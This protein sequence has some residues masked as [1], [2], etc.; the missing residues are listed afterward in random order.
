[1]RILILGNNYASEE[2][3]NLFCEDEQNIVFSDIPTTK[4]YI[5][6]EN[7]N[8][9]LEFCNVNNINLVL[10][11][12][13]EYIDSG[14]Q[15]LLTNENISAFSP[16]IEAISITNSK[17]NA[18]KFMYKNKIQTPKFAIMEKTQLALEYIKNSPIPLAIR[19]DYS[20]KMETVKFCETYNQGQKIV[21][22][23]FLTGNKK[24]IIEDY[25]EG[26]NI[27]VWTISDGFS[28]KIIGTS[29]KYQDEIA[30]F[31]PDFITEE[32]KER[33]LNSAII[34]TI[35]A[36][37]TQDEEYIG[38]LGF[39]FILT[40]DNELFLVG[41]NNFFDDINVNFFTKGY[42][43]NWLDVFE[44][45]IV[46]DVFLKYQFIPKNEYMLSIRNNE[47]IEFICAKTQNNLEKYIKELGYDIKLYKEAN[48]IWKY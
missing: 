9:I 21:N 15:E 33:F 18:K 23:L 22:D 31:E 27:S 17:A 43:I 20:S 47:K 12:N 25:I 4:N 5:E 7:I 32:L 36:L 13:E 26:K 46:G 37:S 41:Y 14:L 16:S 29:V 45:C 6:F 2:F 8:D 40:Y 35:N 34:P 39:D 11:N 48:K 1:M 3:Y 42:D 30:L 19:P 28:A 24:I 44:S 10:I 38:I